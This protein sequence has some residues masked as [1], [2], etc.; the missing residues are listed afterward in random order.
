MSFRDKCRPVMSAFSRMLKAWV[1][2]KAVLHQKRQLEVECRNSTEYS[3]E[4]RA[5]S[6]ILVEKIIPEVAVRKEDLQRTCQDFRT[7][8]S[9][10]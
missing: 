4:V 10:V 2:Y 5:K 8:L 7:T 1:C 6:M 9:C 3:G